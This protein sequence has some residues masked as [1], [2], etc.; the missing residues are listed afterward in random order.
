MPV[1]REAGRDL[2]E[3]R[4]NLVQLVVGQGDTNNLGELEVQLR[5]LRALLQHTI[6]EEAAHIPVSTQP[7]LLPSSH[8]ADGSDDLPVLPGETGG[9]DGS[10]GGLRAALCVHV[11]RR[12]LCVAGAGQ[13]DIGQASSVVAVVALGVG[14]G[15]VVT[16]K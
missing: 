6:I 12:L 8:L 14:G 5:A 4:P 15:I 2:R 10:G 9:R 13:D 11:G 3:T 16:A 7:S 1:A